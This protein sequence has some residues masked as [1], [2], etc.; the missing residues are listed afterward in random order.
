[1]LLMSKLETELR[2]RKATRLRASGRGSLIE[3]K[4][5]VGGSERLS[6]EPEL[7]R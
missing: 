7:D 3:D 1:M 4:A 6:V 2:R 5:T